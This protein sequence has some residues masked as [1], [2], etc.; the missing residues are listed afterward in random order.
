MITVTIRNLSGRSIIGTPGNSLLKTLQENYVDWMH[1]C[2][3]KGR[4]TTCKFRLLEGESNLGSLTAPEHTY[5]GAG[6]LKDHERLACQAIVNGDI[7]IVVPNETKLPHISY[8]DNPAP[9]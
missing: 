5:K 2:G 9:W 7:V 1:S 8:S 6:Q 4:C 3:G